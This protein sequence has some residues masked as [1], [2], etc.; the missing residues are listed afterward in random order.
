MVYLDTYGDGGYSYADYVENCA[1]MECGADV[2]G[3]EDYYRWLDWQIRTDIETFFDNLKYANTEHRPCVISG[4]LGLWWGA[5][6]IEEEMC[7]DLATAVHKCCS[8]CDYMEVT[9]LNGVV[10]VSASHHDGTNNFEIRPLTERG[11]ERMKSG[12]TICVGN[13]W[14]TG[15]YDK[16]LY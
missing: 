8:G 3:S 6:R 13:H 12:K 2:E 1:D 15:K 4:T 9:S 7:S 16:Y 5:A 10:R 11:V 14:H